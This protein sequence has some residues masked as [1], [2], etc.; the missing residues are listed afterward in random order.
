MLEI[1]PSFQAGL[2]SGRRASVQLDVDATA[3]TQ[4]G[5]GAVYIQSIIAQ[6]V[7]GVCSPAARR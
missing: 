3:M 2:L 6:E 4:A 7:T 5:N 1:P